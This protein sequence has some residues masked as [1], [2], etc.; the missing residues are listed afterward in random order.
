MRFQ[1]RLQGGKKGNQ[2]KIWG[3]NIPGTENNKCK[4]SELGACVACPRRSKE[5][6]MLSIE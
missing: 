3:K 5:G 6:S 1:Q 2:E 4:G